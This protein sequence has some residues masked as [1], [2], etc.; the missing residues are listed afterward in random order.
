MA[1]DGVSKLDQLR[2]FDE[3]E[4]RRLSVNGAHDLPTLIDLALKTNPQTRGAWYAALKANAQLGQSEASNYPNIQANAD[5]GYLK[6]P[7][8]FPGQTLVVRNE[9]FLPQIKVSYDLLDFGRSRASER[10]AR[11]QLIA[12]NFAFDQ[13]IQD[14]IFNV[15]KA[16]YVLAAANASVSAAQANPHARAYQLGCGPAAPQRGSR[17][18]AS[19][20]AGERTRSAGRLR[21]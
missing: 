4:V 5:G 11:E 2:R 7:I 14:L 1:D 12:A 19:S 3:T 15:E 18:K 13:A 6:L 21:S 9:A 16:Y 17:N 20:P 10:G 8:Q